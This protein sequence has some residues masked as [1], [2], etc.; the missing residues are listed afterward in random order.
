MAKTPTTKAKP[1]G[2][3]KPSVEE[4][5]RES[6]E[7]GSIPV[8]PQTESEPERELDPPVN[9]DEETRTNPTSEDVGAV[10]KLDR[11]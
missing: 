11:K 2:E 5:R 3:A 7:V 6:Q 8:T 4:T 9:F 10:G 1:E